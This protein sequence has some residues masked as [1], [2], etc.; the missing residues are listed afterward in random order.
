MI[1]DLKAPLARNVD[2]PFFDFRVEEF[3]DVAAVEAYQVVMMPALVELE[4][5]FASLKIVPLQQPG[6][7]ELGQHS[8][9]GGKTD[10]HAV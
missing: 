9:H 3:L 7:L 5:R 8:I 4:H 6:L 2:L 1:L 10:V